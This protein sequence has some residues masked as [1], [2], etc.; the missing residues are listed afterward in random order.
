MSGALRMLRMKP[1]AVAGLLLASAA[2]PMIAAGA[3]APA[4]IDGA[5]VFADNCAACHQASGEGI[6]GAFPKLAGNAFVSGDP[7]KPVGVLLNGRGGMPTFRDDL[8]DAQIAAVLSFVR[9]HWGNSAP[10]IEAAFVAKIRGGEAM[11]PPVSAMQ[12]H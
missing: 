4:P 9:S 10:A 7:A 11:K 5:K 12:A 1:L 3:Q 6:E 2:A 8:S